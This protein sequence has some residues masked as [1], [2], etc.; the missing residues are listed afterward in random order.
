MPQNIL[1]RLCA[2]A[3]KKRKILPRLQNSIL[4]KQKRRPLLR[5]PFKL[6]LQIEL[7]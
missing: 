2:A 3:E 7:S 1:A 4:G 5:T 6:H